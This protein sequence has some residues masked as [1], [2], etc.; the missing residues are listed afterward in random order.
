MRSSPQRQPQGRRRQRGPRSAAGGHRR[1]RRSTT[2]AACRTVIRHICSGLHHRPKQILVRTGR[3]IQLTALGGSYLVD[4]AHDGVAIVCQLLER[5]H[6]LRGWR[7]QSPRSE[8]G[9]S[10]GSVFA[11]A[12]AIAIIGYRTFCAWNESN[13][14]VGSSAMPR[15]QP[16]SM[17]LL[18]PALPK[19]T[20]WHDRAV[21][22]HRQRRGWETQ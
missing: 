21:E 18:K 22:R 17:D 5:L 3:T 7:R 16:I 9:A 14:D 6:H 20:G 11:T 13:P 2:A 12:H 19:A 4:G 8:F 15:E 10:R 1:A